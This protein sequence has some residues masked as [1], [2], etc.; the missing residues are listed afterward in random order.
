[1]AFQY[2]ENHE[3]QALTFDPVT[4][5]GHAWNEDSYPTEYDPNWYWLYAAPPPAFAWWLLF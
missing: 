1:M 4:R 5:R 3:P 2:F